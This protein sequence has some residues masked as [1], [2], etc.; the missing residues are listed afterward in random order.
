[1]CYK[2]RAI[3][4]FR[5]IPDEIG[6]LSPRYRCL[7]ALILVAGFLCQTSG[8]ASITVFLANAYIGSPSRNNLLGLVLV[9]PCL[10]VLSF[11]WSGRVQKRTFSPS[12][13]SKDK[14][15]VVML[16]TGQAKE[17]NTIARWKASKLMIASIQ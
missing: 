9:I 10:V 8:L 11:S 5:P 2:A 13:K 15:K 12:E 6:N 17:L 3:N 1:M 14:A 16:K 7:I 4:G